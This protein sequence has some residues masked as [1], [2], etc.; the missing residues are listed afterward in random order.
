MDIKEKFKSFMDKQKI[1]LKTPSSQA[2]LGESVKSDDFEGRMAVTGDLYRKSSL[3]NDHILTPEA[4]KAVIDSIESL[5]FESGDVDVGEHELKKFP[6]DV[7]IHVINGM[8]SRLRKQHAIVSRRV[9]DLIMQKQGLCSEE[10]EKVVELQKEIYMEIGLCVEGRRKLAQGRSQFTSASLGIL[11]NY[12]KRQKI[13][14]VIRSLRT[15]RTLQM[16]DVQLQNLLKAEDYPGAIQLLLECQKAAAT[17]KHFTC[18]SELSTKLQDTL[19]GAEEQLDVALAKVAANFNAANYEKLQIAY[20]LLGKTQTLMDQLHMHLT[21]HIHNSAFTIV[22]GYV[23]LYNS[24][25]GGN[26]SISGSSFS[27]MQYSELCKYVN[28][29]SFLPCLMDLSKSMWNVLKSYR[30]IILW[31]EENEKTSQEEANNE[32][33]DAEEAATS[34]RYTKQKLEHGLYRIWQDVQAKVRTFILASDL[35]HFKFDDFL[36]ILDVIN[37]LIDVGECFCGSKSETLRESIKKQSIN[38]FRTHHRARMEELHMFLENEG[39]EAC[40][41][42]STFSIYQLMEFRF[43]KGRD[44]SFT[45]MS[46]PSSSPVKKSG[47]ITEKRDLFDLFN[48]D[49]SPFDIATEETVEEDIMAN[50]EAGDSI[51]ISDDDSEDDEELMKDFVDEQTGEAP[52]PH[53]RRKFDHSKAP[54]VTNTTLTILRLIG[55]YIQMMRLLQPIAFDVMVCLSHLF[56][57]YLYTVFMFFGERGELEQNLS[58]RLRTSLKRIQDTL[59]LT[60][61]GSQEEPIDQDKVPSPSISPV[62]DTTSAESIYGL[63]VRVV[64]VESLA[65][66]AVQLEALHCH[67]EPLIPQQRRTFL[68]QF[69]TGTV[70]ITPEIRHH[71]YTAVASQVIDYDG[72]LNRMSNVKWDIND[73]MSQHSQYVDVLLRQLQVLSMKLEDVSKVSP[74]PAEAYD[75]LWECIVRITNRTLL[76]G[77]ASARRCTNEGRSL[78]QLDYQQFL[79]KLECLTKVRPLPD[80]HLVETFI[81][82]YYL[83][84]GALEEWV[85]QNGTDYSPRQLNALMSTMT[86]VN[87]RTRQKISNLLEEQCRR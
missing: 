58:R 56:D 49:S 25:N 75:A 74:I 3:L 62:V 66:L 85:Q 4:E 11:A 63:P 50:G 47:S 5:Y 20:G 71:V 81:K 53:T 38:Y 69:Y 18:I 51:H 41:V 7:D 27:K 82:A 23:E 8:R 84:E 45:R 59:I 1:S 28:E 61:E 21:S 26:G 30:S 79:M 42:K 70:K 34:R 52:Q 73:L 12:S 44:L 86:H 17:F 19:E 15:V 13:A 55:K 39:W 32:S 57:Y 46:T 72:I 37:K 60:S 35:C 14:S 10:M 77:F 87:K 43:L 83:P 2:Q 33:P 48:S 65:F 31:H 54:I 6:Q 64:A 36:R 68:Q 78:M 16:T 67:I 40:P 80:K 9:S 29:E 76:E 24:I 22:L